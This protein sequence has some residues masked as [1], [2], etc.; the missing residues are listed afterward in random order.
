MKIMSS[1]RTLLRE[2]AVAIDKA[3]ILVLFSYYE[4]FGKIGPTQDEIFKATRIPKKSIKAA[5]D[6]LVDIGF[7]KREV[8]PHNRRRVYPSNI[9]SLDVDESSSLILDHYSSRYTRKET[10]PGYVQTGNSSNSPS[11]GNLKGRWTAADIA[12]DEDWKKLKL[13]LLKYFKPSEVNPV[14][15]TK[16]NYFGKLLTLVGNVDFEAYC[17]WYRVNKYPSKKFHFGLFLYPSMLTE[18][19]DSKEDDPYLNVSTKMENSE[20]YRRLLEEQEKTLIAEFG[21]DGA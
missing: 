10:R 12:N 16:K 2:L 4:D 17:K 18:Y 11:G 1:T 19:E 15:L 9:S 20:G 14:F 21:D 6:G 8:T 5:T 7:L 13:V 3:E